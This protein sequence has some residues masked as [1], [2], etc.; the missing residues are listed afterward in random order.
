MFLSRE[1]DIRGF[2]HFSVIYYTLERAKNQH[3]RLRILLPFS[4]CIVFLF[5]VLAYHYLPLVFKRNDLQKLCCYATI[6]YTILAIMRSPYRDLDMTT[7]LDENSS[8][9][10]PISLRGER[11]FMTTYLTTYGAKIEKSM[12]EKVARN[13]WFYKIAG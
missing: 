4:Y 3:C 6:L 2:Y 8:S 12:R 9:G 13:K 1:A 5:F 10:R 7:Y 11:T